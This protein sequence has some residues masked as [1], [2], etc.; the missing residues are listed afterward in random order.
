MAHYDEDGVHPVNRIT[1]GSIGEPGRRAFVLQAQ[2]GQD[3]ISWVIEK[4]Q[5]IGLRESIPELLAEIQTEFPE[6]DAPLVAHQ[7][8]LA[9]REPLEPAFRVGSIGLGYDRFHD[10]VVFTLVDAAVFD[11]DLGD[12]SDEDVASV[13]LY[14]YT[15]RGQ[16][17]LL[18]LQAEEAVAAGRPFCPLCGEPIDDFGHF[19]LPAAAR[20]TR[21]GEYV[22]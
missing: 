4:E 13:E 1:A 7:P 18:S 2:I 3:L 9:L 19:C 6:L 11:L 5:A 8:N 14:I 17:L 15:T 22:Q 10:L 21:D 16:A 20:G 12:F